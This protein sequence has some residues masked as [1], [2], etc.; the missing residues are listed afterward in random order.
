MRCDM[1][2]WSY[3]Q[4]IES[5]S[6]LVGRVAFLHALVLGGNYYC[7]IAR[8]VSSS[9]LF[10]LTLTTEE[11]ESPTKLKLRALP[12]AFPHATRRR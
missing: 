5:T 12:H 8:G 6:G 10:T 9:S 11:K 3:W 7:N 1:F 4:H 2:L